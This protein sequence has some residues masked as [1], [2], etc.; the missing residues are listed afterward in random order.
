MIVLIFIGPKIFR[1]FVGIRTYVCRRQGSSGK[2]ARRALIVSLYSKMVRT[3]AVVEIWFVFSLLYCL[4]GWAFNGPRV[5]S[6]INYKSMKDKLKW[7]KKKY[8]RENVCFQLKDV[9][10]RLKYKYSAS[11]TT[12]TTTTTTAKN[13]GKKRIGDDCFQWAH[14]CFMLFIFFFVASFRHSSQN[15]L[16]YSCTVVQLLSNWIYIDVEIV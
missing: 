14:F 3:Y 1:H 8:E 15:T 5:S 9:E 7:K 2:W 12:S 13:E 6:S 10:L 16:R 11:A 4:N